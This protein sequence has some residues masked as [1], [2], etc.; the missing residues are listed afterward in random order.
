VQI[1]LWRENG[2]NHDIPWRN[3]ENR[4]LTISH[5]RAMAGKPDPP[6]RAAGAEPA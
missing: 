2:K 6:W 4:K 5:F 1:A 3:S